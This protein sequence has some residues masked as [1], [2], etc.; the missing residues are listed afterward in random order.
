VNVGTDMFLLEVSYVKLFMGIYNTEGE[1]SDFFGKSVGSNG[2]L[3]G[4]TSKMMFC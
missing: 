2:V 3:L 4:H 1:T